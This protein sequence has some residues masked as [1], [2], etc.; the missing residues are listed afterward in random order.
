MNLEPLKIIAENETF[1][2]ILSIRALKNIPGQLSYKLI[3]ERFM[4]SRNKD[5]ALQCLKTLAYKGKWITRNDI[6]KI[7]HIAQISNDHDVLYA[8]NQ[9][10]VNL[11]ELYL[12]NRDS[13]EFDVLK[14]KTNVKEIKKESQNFGVYLTLDTYNN[15][16]VPK[17]E[18]HAESH[19]DVK[20]YGSRVRLLTAG[21]VNSLSNGNLM[22]TAFMTLNL[23]GS[24]HD[25]S[26]FEYRIE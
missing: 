14:L 7:L 23:F 20:I 19:I 12:R 18:I 9:M 5:E 16:H 25:R 24:E 4:K 13:K 11:Q 10:L 6:D 21:F 17:F 26:L 8:T 22:S 1:Y 2:R 3:L 15:F